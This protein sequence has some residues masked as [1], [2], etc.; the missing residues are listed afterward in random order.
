MKHLFKL[1]FISFILLT[2]CYGEIPKGE[3]SNGFYKYQRRCIKSHKVT[4][5][6]IQ[7]MGKSMMAIPYESSVCDSFINEKIYILPENIDKE[8]MKKYLKVKYE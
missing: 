1:L 7:S 5:M 4:R 8:W 3:D 6:R 2:S